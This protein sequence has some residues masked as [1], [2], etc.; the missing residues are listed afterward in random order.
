[1]VTAEAASVARDARLV[2]HPVPLA[3]VQRRA[4]VAILE[5]PDVD[6]RVAAALAVQLRA[7][8]LSV[9][10]RGRVRVRVRVRLRVRVRVRVRGP[11][12]PCW[13][14]LTARPRYQTVSDSVR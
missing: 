6:Q 14:P 5:A 3:G 1:M 11:L 2:A 13:P 7:P 10:V 9:R 12:A 4:G 8:L